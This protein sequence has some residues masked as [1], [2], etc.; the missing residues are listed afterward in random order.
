MSNALLHSFSVSAKGLG[1]C[2]FVMLL[3]SAAVLAQTQITSETI[4]GTV[5]DE[6]GAFV[7][8]ASIEIRNVDTNYSRSATTDDE[9]RFVALLLPSGKYTITVTKTGF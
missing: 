7:P 4:Q 6:K 9:G 2:L 5:V 1:I 8:G 3:F